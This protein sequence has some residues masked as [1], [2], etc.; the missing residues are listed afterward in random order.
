MIII[1]ANRTGSLCCQKL[2]YAGVA[3]QII[4]FL[5]FLRINNNFHTDFATKMLVERG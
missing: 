3:K 4:A 5:A 1:F 2:L